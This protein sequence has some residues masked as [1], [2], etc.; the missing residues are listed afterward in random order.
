MVDLPTR[1]G[2]SISRAVL[3]SDSAF[4]VDSLPYIFLLY[5]IHL[6]SGGLFLLSRRRKLVLD[7]GRQHVPILSLRKRVH[8]YIQPSGSGDNICRQA[9]KYPGT[10]MCLHH[11]SDWLSS[12][13][14]KVLL[15]FSKDIQPSGSGDTAVSF[16]DG[17]RA[18]QHS[19][20]ALAN[21]QALIAVRKQFPLFF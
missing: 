8:R 12:S 19:A 4:H 20:E 21:V 10:G 5:M 3:P 9:L 14:I 1:L 2:P 18:A 13:E 6:L 17:K 15:T 16:A 7:R 11:F